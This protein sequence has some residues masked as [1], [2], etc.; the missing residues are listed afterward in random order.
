MRKSGLRRDEAEEPYWLCRDS[1][2]SGSG[3]K[4]GDGVFQPCDD[5][6]AFALLLRTIFHFCLPFLHQPQSH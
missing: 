5:F 3:N 1:R 4:C 2:T 6:V